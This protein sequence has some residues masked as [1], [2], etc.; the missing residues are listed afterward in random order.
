MGASLD[1]SAGGLR[2]KEVY[3][4]NMGGCVVGWAMLIPRGNVCVL[5][6]LWIEPASIGTGI[7]SGL[8][9]HAAARATLLGAQRMEWEAEPN[10]VGFYE[11]MGGHYLRESEPSEWGRIVPVMSIDLV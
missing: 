9:R 7:G 1:F 11:K 4:A 2:G 8:F 6:H 3:V 5:D 10:A